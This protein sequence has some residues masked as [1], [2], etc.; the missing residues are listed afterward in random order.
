MI[1]FNQLSLQVAEV[2]RR[3]GQ[4][5]HQEAA[6]FDR[7]RIQHK[8]LHDMVSYVD[9]EAEKLLVAGLR[10]LLP[11][12]GFITEEGTTG[13]SSQAT[14]A[15]T[16]LTWII[17]PLDGTTNFIHGLPIYSVSVALMQGR[18]LVIG[19][20]YEVNQ[21]ECFRAVRGGGAFCNEQPIRVSSTQDLNHSLIATGFPYSNFNRIDTYLPILKEF[22]RRTNG[23]RRVG[24]AAIDLAWVAAGRF[25]G[26]FEFN[27]NSYDVAAGILLVR[28]AGG[29]VTQFLHDGDP[30][31]GREVVASN[32]AVHAEMQEVI[33]EHWPA[34]APA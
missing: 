29:H 4:F 1:D 25:D 24:S 26:Y 2:A 22:M 12:A 32:T 14:S 31:F 15:G 16:G 19:V 13:G 23:V 10:E 7:G 5:I 33:G 28:E 20:V 11:E 3:A 30:I 27:I 18:E 8:G 21:Q 17:D 9:Q 6:T 34:H